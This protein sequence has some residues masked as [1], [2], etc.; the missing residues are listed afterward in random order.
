M[1]LGK[2][3]NNEVIDQWTHYHLLILVA[4][5]EGGYSLNGFLF[6]REYNSP[7]AMWFTGRLSAEPKCVS[8]TKPCV[9]FGS[10]VCRFP[11]WS[12][13]LVANKS[14]RN[15]VHYLMFSSVLYYMYM[16]LF[17]INVYNNCWLVEMY[18][19]L[20]NYL[21]SVLLSIYWVGELMVRTRTE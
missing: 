6:P 12:T 4:S 15:Y 7:M 2:H 10:R 19:S 3:S 5:R 1:V 9:Y 21:V 13:I 8:P 14:P 20:H 11:H 17:P 16:A 18:T